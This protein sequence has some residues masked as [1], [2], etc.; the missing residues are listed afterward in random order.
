MIDH[1]RLFKEL[2]TT[3]FRE[4]LELFVPEIANTIDF[5]SIRFLPQEYF[6]DLTA[7]EDKIIDLLV[8]VK[9]AGEDIGFLVHVEAQSYSQADFAR[10]M[11]FYFA[12]LYQKYVQK[13]YPIVVFSFDEPLRPEPESH[14]VN[15]PGLKVLEFNFAAIQLN[16]LSWRD[17]LNQ[18]NPVAAALMAKMQIAPKDRPLVKAECLRILATLR[19]D[20]ARTRLISSFVDTYL[21]LDESEERLFAE[22][23]GKLET[24]EQERVME[25][26]TSWGER[27]ERSL[28]Q[29]Q[30]TRRF[31]EVPESVQTLVAALPSEQ[32]ESLALDLLDFGDLTDLE[33]WLEHP[34]G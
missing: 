11:F 24:S 21:I 33:K 16:R 23:V 34:Q 7:G 19:L 25:I 15:F 2:L 17:F 27:A 29:K 28:V 31:G 10:R 6:G 14:S 1:D 8:E 3:F 32:I 18:Q 22:E 13:I 20:G 26:K 9:Q 12:R 4:F 30:L 5:S